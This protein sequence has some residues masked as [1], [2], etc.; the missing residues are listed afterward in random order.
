MGSDKYHRNARIG[1]AYGR[2]S[3]Y[4]DLDR[5][6]AELF[7]GYNPAKSPSHQF[8]DGGDMGTEEDVE[9]IKQQTRQLKQ[10]DVG[11]TRNALRTAYETEQ[12]ARD[13]LGKIGDQSERLANSERY[14]DMS[15]TKAGAAD[16]KVD[17]LKKLN[18]SI[19]RPVITFHKDAKRAAQEAKVQQRYEEERE[20]RAQAMMEVRGTKNRLEQAGEAGSK[21][22]NGNERSAADVA[23]RK[24]QRQRYQFEATE[25]DEELEDELDDNLDEIGSVAERLKA[26]GSAMG[27]E[28]DDQTGRVQRIG[29]KSASLD[30]GI[31]SSTQ[32]MKKFAK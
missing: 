15:K 11:T 23:V 30:T 18:R 17:E 28:I 19:F 24:D 20:G 5:D 6:R 27:E 8:E 14:L 1:D 25:S 3:E 2:G 10:E 13:T 7:A 26:L 21:F 4:T 22:G 31:F 12:V 29:D 32:R 16:D 9:S